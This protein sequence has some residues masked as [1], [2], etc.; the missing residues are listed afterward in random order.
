[1]TASGPPE[2]PSFWLG[3][4]DTLTYLL[5]HEQ[6][7]AVEVELHRHRQRAG[8]EELV[9]RAEG[10]LR[11]AKDG[12][13]VLRPETVAVRA[14][15]LLLDGRYRAEGLVLRI[16]SRPRGY[17]DGVDPAKDKTR[18]KAA[19]RPK[20]APPPEPVRA[21]Q[22]ALDEKDLVKEGRG[23]ADT[24][25]RG[26]GWVNTPPLAAGEPAIRVWARWSKRKDLARA[27]H[28]LILNPEEA[29]AAYARE[30]GRCP[31]CGGLLPTEAEATFAPHPTCATKRY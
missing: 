18:S 2:R 22:L 23:S 6:F 29:Q 11:R 25:W 31:V 4:R 8:L 28:R 13:V 3:A 10:A 1:M 15:G 16:V 21:L 24:G 19:T 9:E 26:V 7:E 27:V 30:V 17:M 5:A 20:G 14:P 12:G